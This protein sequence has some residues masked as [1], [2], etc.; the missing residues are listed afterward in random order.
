MGGIR[1]RL[2]AVSAPPRALYDGRAIALLTQ[3]GKERVIAP[4]FRR[5]LG[6]RVER[7][8]GYDTDRLG[9]FTREIPRPGTQREAARRKARI[10]MELAGL[11]CG[12]ASEGAFGPDPHAGL[13][14]W[15]VELVMLVDDRACVEVCGIAEGPAR[16]VHG[17]VET[18]K[19]L[20]ALARKAGFPHH[21]LV[22]RPDGEND[23]RLRKG[24][25]ERRSLAEAFDWARAAS[26]SGCVFVENDLRAH[27]NPT[28]MRT[29]RAAAEDLVRRLRSRCPACGAPGYWLV[30][31]LTGLPCAACGSPTREVSAE[32][33]GCVNCSHGEVRAR[34][35]RPHA[36]P[37]RCDVCNP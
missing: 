29:I 25:S 11:T 2:G 6:A 10:G 14:P 16:H 28:R 19:A 9:T 34:T 8:A 4:L 22:V 17:R 5:A 23:P 30:E 35:D 26:T 24:I 21:H 15:N 20:N 27:A 13:F 31:R 33:H 32:R 12:L 1:P 18:L 3:H 37:S 36:D 7:V